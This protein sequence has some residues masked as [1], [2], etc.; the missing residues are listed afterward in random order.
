VLYAASNL[1][2]M[3]ALLGYPLLVEPLLPLQ[4]QTLLWAGLYFALAALIAVCALSAARLTPQDAET[5]K[6]VEADSNPTAG[7]TLQDRLHWVALAF[8]PSSLMLGLTTY[9][10]TDVAPMPMIWVIP[11]A[12]YLLSFI[13]VFARPPALVQAVLVRC[14]PVLVLLQVFFLIV[15]SIQFTWLQML[16]CL[17]VF[18]VACMTCH[19]ELAT[20]RPPPAFLTSFYLWLSVGGVLG[21]VFNALVAP[22]VF[23]SVVEYPLVTVVA[24]LLLPRPPT[25]TDTPTKR[26]LD[27][28]GPLVVGSIT[29][30][31]L[32]WMEVEREPVMSWLSGYWQAVECYLGAQQDLYGPTWAPALVKLGL[33]L[34]LCLEFLRRPLRFGLGIAAVMLASAWGNAY[35]NQHVLL[36]ERSFFGTHRLEVLRPARGTR[37]GY[38]LLYHGT[39][40]HGLQLCDAQNLPIRYSGPL[41]YF[42]PTGPIGQVFA[43]REVT[44]DRSPV[45][46]V[47]LGAGSLAFYGE[48]G[49]EFTFYEID[50]VVERI[51]RK[52]FSFLRDAQEREVKVGVVLGDAR[53]T[54]AHAPDHHY[55]LIVLDAFSSDAPP[56][57]LLTREALELY[58]N[59][60]APGGILAFD[61]T[62]RYLDLAPVLANLAED[63]GLQGRLVQTDPQNPAVA[64]FESRWVLLYR[65]ALRPASLTFP[66]AAPTAAF[67]A[68]VPWAA[69]PMNGNAQDLLAQ[70]WRWRRTSLQTQ[71]EVG[72]WKD[73]YSNL[74]RILNWKGR[75]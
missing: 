15:Q 59:K 54:L 52:D 38:L 7:P 44:L 10:S 63:A 14:L 37:G 56:M 62:N 3:I 69:L 25:A 17:V 34:L 45:A 19:G 4:Q 72:V 24:C 50:P 18:F 9:L 30:C 49:Q 57:H 70:D 1:G 41:G 31:L 60:L 47:G 28:L 16:V 23:K 75:N 71:A 74:F 32:I 2:S 66:A 27:I 8:V 33:P 39:T 29:M 36:R 58:L 64:K 5:L 65:P 48:P 13:L 40:L 55:G 35:V 26:W 21:G 53:L 6:P 67:P 46:V 12:L 22:L 73:D 20:R 43:A 11:L 68:A 51:A 42:H 61:I